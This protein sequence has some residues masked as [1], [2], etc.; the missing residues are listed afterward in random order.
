MRCPLIKSLKNDRERRWI[1]KLGRLRLSAAD[2]DSPGCE[3]VV[4]AFLNKTGGHVRWII[5]W[6]L[7]TMNSRY[8]AESEGRGKSQDCARLFKG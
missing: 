5:R 6:Y 7:T 1:G 2:E 8:G 4:E 3:N